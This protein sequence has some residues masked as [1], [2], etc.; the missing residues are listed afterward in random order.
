MCPFKGRY[1]SLPAGFCG[2]CRFFLP[3]FIL[4]K[5]TNGLY[6][7]PGMNSWLAGKHSPETTFYGWL[8]SFLVYLF[9]PATYAGDYYA[10]QIKKSVFK[11]QYVI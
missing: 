7:M 11:L 10:W 8:R 2:T 4:I 3:V 5:K 9:G 1:L 6:R